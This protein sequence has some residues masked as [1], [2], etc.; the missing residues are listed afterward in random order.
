MTPKNWTTN[1]RTRRLTRSSMAALWIMPLLLIDC[2]VPSVAHPLPAATFEAP[3]SC[4]DFDSGKISELD[5]TAQYGELLGRHIKIFLLSSRTLWHATAELERDLLEACTK[6]GKSLGVSVAEMSAVPSGDGQVARLV[7]TAVYRKTKEALD[8]VGPGRLVLNIGAP[9]CH[10][11]INTMLRCLD[12]CGSPASDR[13]LAVDCKGGVISGQCDGRCLGTCAS[14]A[15]AHCT[16]T[17]LGVCVGGCTKEFTGYCQSCTGQCGDKPAKEA[18]CPNVCFG[19]CDERGEGRCDGTCDGDCNGPCESV[20]AQCE[21]S[22]TGGCSGALREPM[23]SG[24]FEPSGA[25]PYCLATCG[26]M[27]T[28]DIRCDP[29]I[30][31]MTIVGD[32]GLSDI[33]QAL[34]IDASIPRIVQTQLGRGKRM[35]EALNTLAATGAM[36]RYSALRVDSANGKAIACIDFAMWKIAG[37]AMAVTVGTSGSADVGPAATKGN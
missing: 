19:K 20:V 29:P 27:S 24:T 13:T 35:L 18:D 32:P 8:A 37:A 15:G 2:R 36:L 22:C 17:C 6:L 30:V 11:N 4:E 26:A 14:V 16:G 1:W 25:S 28:A 12:D 33:R 21:G 5:F 23:C 9:M 10:L 3:H 7:C 31:N 34:A